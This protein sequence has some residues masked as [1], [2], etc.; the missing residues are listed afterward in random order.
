MLAGILLRLLAIF[1]LTSLS[2]IV[3][4]LGNAVPLGQLMF[5]RAIVSVVPILI[6]LQIRGQIPSLRTRYPGKHVVRGIVG[7]MAMSL[8]FA[9]LAT[10]PVATAQ[11]LGFLGPVLSLPLAALILREKV[12]A[13]VILGVLLGFAGMLMMLAHAIEA[14]RPGQL[15]GVLCGLG[16][17]LCIAFNRIQIKA[18]TATESTGAIAFYF[19]VAAAVFGLVISPPWIWALDLSQ[20]QM[21]LIASAGLVG[22]LGHIAMTEA[23]ARAPVSALAAFEFTALIWATGFDML[24]FAHTPGWL[25]AA[26]ILTICLAAVVALRPAR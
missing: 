5:F 17:A 13:Q 21:L 9:S 22:G 1:L 23:T 16:F 10:L 8:S 15:V 20:S 18:M 26:G 4:A 2:A 11:A 19:T 6:Y 14:P 3:H 24:L 25:E 7:A 12:S